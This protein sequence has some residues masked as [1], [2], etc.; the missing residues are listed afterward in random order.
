MIIKRIADDA[1]VDSARLLEIATT[2]D[3]RY[4]TYKIPKR[5]GG[6]R[7]ISHPTP[8]VKFLQRWLNRNVFARLPVHDAA[9]AYRRKIGIADN[10][11]MHLENNYLLKID[12]TDFFPSLKADDVR[13]VLRRNEEGF[14]F[15][16]LE[17]D[18]ELIVSIVCRKGALTIGAPSSPILSNAIMY[19][20]D[21]CL[22]DFCVDSE[23]VYTRYADDIFL[24]T[25]QPDVLSDVLEYVR[26]DLEARGSP[27][28][29][30]NE[31][32]TVFT[33]KKRRRLV[34]GLILTSEGKVSIGRKNKRMIK[35]QVYSYLKGELDK[36]SVAYLKG[37][38]AFAV[39]VEPEFVR[40]LSL[41]YGKNVLEKL[42]ED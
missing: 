18:L 5:K 25:R 7:V 3:H 19:E 9:F 17:N 23:V 33:S 10:A 32:K 40:G 31:A 41:K 29:R 28:L 38:L 1:G 26:R 36:E 2:S 16:A 6:V 15:G 42:R 27:I 22:Y 8:E 37:Y 12:F 39:S 30:I 34:T 20:F 24:S 13:R 21:T 11:K 4:R 14:S 35:G